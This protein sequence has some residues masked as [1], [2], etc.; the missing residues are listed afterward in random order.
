MLAALALAAPVRAA[1]AQQLLVPKDDAQQNHLKA[2]GLT[3]AALKAG[4]KGE[5]LLNYRGGSFL[6]ADTP[7]TRRRAALEGVSIEPVDA[8]QPGSLGYPCT[9]DAECT[10]GPCLPK[11]P[12]NGLYDYSPTPV[13][14]TNA[15]L[16]SE[17][18][19]TPDFTA[20]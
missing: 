16:S 9:T 19:I 14:P 13:L 6:L 8:G 3:F 18:F 15:Y 2:Y 12:G 10:V 4:Q 1:G 11:G 5:W 20:S 7:D 17:Y